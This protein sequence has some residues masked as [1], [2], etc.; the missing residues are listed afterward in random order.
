MHDELIDDLADAAEVIADLVDSLPVDTRRRRPADDEWSVA[1]IVG[2]LRAADAIWSP[3][4]LNAIVHDGVH[5]PD[6]D[7]R[8]MQAVLD[9]GGLGLADQVTAYAFARAELVGILRALTDDEWS[10]VC[11]HAT[12][13]DMAVVDLASTLARH[14]AE[15]LEQLQRT[16]ASLRESF[17]PGR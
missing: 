5:M 12:R 14:E 11:V 7:E 4:I 6:V 2:H 9:A 1:E 17:E 16:A 13:A 3:R 10:H 15:H 8:A